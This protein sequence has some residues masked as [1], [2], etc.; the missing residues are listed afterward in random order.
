[1]PILGDNSNFYHKQTMKW[2]KIAI[3]CAIILTGIGMVWTFY[4]NDLNQSEK[5]HTISEN[6]QILNNSSINID[7]SNTQINDDS[8]IFEG[9]TIKNYYDKS[10]KNESTKINI[11]IISS[12]EKKYIPSNTNLTITKAVNI[13]TVPTLQL[14]ESYQNKEIRFNHTINTISSNI[15]SSGKYVILD[16]EPQSF[17]PLHHTAWIVLYPAY[18]DY[19]TIKEKNIQVFLISDKLSMAELKKSNSWLGQTQVN[20]PTGEQPHYLLFTHNGTN[21]VKWEFKLN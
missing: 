15:F 9:D 10:T 5:S 19:E 3:V 6:I 7:N 18:P 17:I 21:L 11:E 2:T 20:L 1:M 12:D 13:L 8:S 16:S 4:L 14:G